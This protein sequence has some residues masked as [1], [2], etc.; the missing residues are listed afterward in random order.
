MR[1][2]LIH[3]LGHGLGL[4]HPF[5]EPDVLG[6][7]AT[8]PYLPTNEDSRSSTVMSYSGSNSI[9]LREFDIAALQ[10]LYGVNPAARAGNDT[11]V[12][13]SSFPNFIWDGNGT[14]VIDASTSSKAVHVYLE[15]GYWGYGGDTRAGIISSRGQI[16]VNFG[17]VIENLIGS[18]FSDELTGNSTS[19]IISGGYGNDSI[20]GLAGNDTLSG[21]IG[22]NILDG[23]DGIDIAKYSSGK[24]NWAVS[25]QGS[26]LL[27]TDIIGITSDTLISIERM[28]FQDTKLAF[29]LDGNAGQAV[30]IAAAIYGKASVNDMKLIGSL[31][32]QL[33]SGVAF[34]DV[35]QRSIT[36]KFSNTLDPWIFVTTVYKNVA[37]VNPDLGTLGHYASLLLSGVNSPVEL[38]LIGVEHPA[39]IS[40]IQGMGLSVNGLQY[41]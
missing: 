4:K 29:D 28:W 40:V 31:L 17:T 39:N 16:T 6:Y 38:A 20:K 32:S 35:I 21:D 27:V 12:Y 15:P 19:N 8:P 22:R 7:V 5:D 34:N 1:P 13:S 9:S 30:K 26:S 11:Y 24:F 14:D 3:E 37:G 18:A 36:S 23:G 2:V 10:Y 33:D 25:K 41:T